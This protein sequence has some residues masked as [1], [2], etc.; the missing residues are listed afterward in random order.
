MDNQEPQAAPA[1]L[2]LAVRW[3]RLRA[4]YRVANLA[5]HHVLGF[6]IKL[7]LL[8]YFSL[9]VLFLVL[10]YAVLPNIDM[11]KGD[12]ER[13]ASRALGGRV[14]IAAI[15][16]SWKGLRPALALRD[17]RLHDRA[18]RQVSS[19]VAGGS[20]RPSRVTTAR[21]S[22]LTVWPGRRRWACR[23]LYLQ[24]FPR[25]RTGGRSGAPAPAGPRPGPGARRRRPGPG[26]R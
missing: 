21:F 24:S 9:A 2:P 5:S 25:S 26:R 10:R 4:A 23:P 20:A 16:A 1:H 7:F 13:A 17:V 11:Y 19:R 6:A 14:T 8:V 18:G 15:D 12:I 3:R 22:R